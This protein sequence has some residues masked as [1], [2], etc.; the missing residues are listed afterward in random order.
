MSG[1]GKRCV[2]DQG[3]HESQRVLSVLLLIL[4]SIVRVEYDQ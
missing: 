3:S 2:G 1:K 4:L